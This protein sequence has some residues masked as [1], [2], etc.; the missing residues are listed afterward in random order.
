MRNSKKTRT[1][2]KAP[3]KKDRGGKFD[4]QNWIGKLGVEFHPYS[5]S[6]EKRYQFFGSG[7]FLKKR[8]DR[9]DHGINRLDRIARQHDIDYSKAKSLED[10]WKADDKMV[11]SIKNLPGK[12]S[13]MDHLARYIIIFI[14][15]KKQLKL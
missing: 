3:P 11:A 4:I 7:T 6:K 12:K 9:G 5:S 15:S 1:K 13:M 10:K 2:R 8:L 14:N